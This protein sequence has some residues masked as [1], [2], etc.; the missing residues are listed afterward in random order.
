MHIY[1]IILRRNDE[2][3][4]MSHIVLGFFFSLVV[5]VS[6]IALSFCRHRKT[7]YSNNYEIKILFSWCMNWKMHRQEFLIIQW[8]IYNKWNIIKLKFNTIVP[9]SK[10]WRRIS[11]KLLDYSTVDNLELLKRR[12]WITPFFS[13]ILLNRTF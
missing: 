11:V 10:Q 1:D 4:R 5:D 2:I 13:I 3:S 8:Y 9:I 6:V 7:W 12:S